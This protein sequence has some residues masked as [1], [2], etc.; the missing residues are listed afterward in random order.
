MTA[1]NPLNRPFLCHRAH[2]SP[3]L[4]VVVDEAMKIIAV[5]NQKIRRLDGGYGRRTALVREEWHFSEEF[6]LLEA[7]LAPLRVDLHGAAG[8]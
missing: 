8:N 7:P 6:P 1:A 4:G 2:V 3:D 5:E